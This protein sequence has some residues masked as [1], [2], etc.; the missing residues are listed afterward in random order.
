MDR[1]QC[2]GC[3]YFKPAHSNGK[4]AYCFCHHLLDTGKRRQVGENDKCLSWT[5]KH[6]RLCVV[7]EIP[8]A[9]R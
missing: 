4:G 9:Q 6:V 5:K 8:P 3:A 1:G 7:G 2:K